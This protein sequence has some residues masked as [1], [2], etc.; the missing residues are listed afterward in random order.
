MGAAQA[1]SLRRMASTTSSD[2]KYPG[3]STEKLLGH[4]RRSKNN[5]EFLTN[6]GREA[7]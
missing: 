5:G 7:G 4:L 3:E 6:L 1:R 2:E